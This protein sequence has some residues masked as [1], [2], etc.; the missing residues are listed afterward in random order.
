MAGHDASD[1]WIL[2]ALYVS[3][4]VTLIGDGITLYHGASGGP[5][6][7]SSTDYYL[8]DKNTDTVFK[9]N[10]EQIQQMNFDHNM[11]YCDQMEQQNPQMAKQLRQVLQPA[12]FSQKGPE[13]EMMAHFCPTGNSP[14]SL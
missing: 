11:E 1:G 9:F 3:V 10:H 6:P 13:A 14:V 4:F 12:E 8:I 7:R 5:D 2:K